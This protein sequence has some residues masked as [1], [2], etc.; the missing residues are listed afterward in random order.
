MNNKDWKC[1]KCGSRK[2]PNIEKMNEN[3]DLDGNRGVMV[4]WVT[5][6]ECGEEH[7]I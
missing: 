3:T 5:C 1:E 2:L 6:R 4:T 7:G